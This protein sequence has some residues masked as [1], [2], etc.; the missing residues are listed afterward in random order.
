M[1]SLRTIARPYTLPEH[2]NL[3]EADR[4]VWHLLP[5]TTGAVYD[6]L[7]AAPGDVEETEEQERFCSACGERGKV[8]VIVRHKGPPSEGRLMQQTL[9]RALGGVDNIA[10]DGVAAPWPEDIADRVAYLR[11]LPVHWVQRVF[12]EARKDTDIDQE[13]EREDSDSEPSC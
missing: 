12:V 7:D 6:A 1:L 3:A 13:E 2:A 5:V 10:F 11:K 8:N 9:A 4:P